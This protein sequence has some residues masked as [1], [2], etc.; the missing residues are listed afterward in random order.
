MQ[1]QQIYWREA[2]KGLQTLPYFLGISFVD[3]YYVFLVRCLPLPA[4]RVPHLCVFRMLAGH[5][6]RNMVRK[7][8]LFTHT[9]HRALAVPDEN[10]VKCP[11]SHVWMNGAACCLQAP[12]IFVGPYWHLTLPATSIITYYLVGFAVT[13][14]GSGVAYML[15]AVLPVNSVLVGTVFTCLVVGAFLSGTGPSIASARGTVIEFV[16]SASYSRCEPARCSV[17]CGKQIH[18]MWH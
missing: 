4:L 18:R 10:V 5:C 13:F 1:E 15:S 16:L 11:A 12:M 7:A 14:W 17:E 3:M 2:S 8:V 9:S 6:T